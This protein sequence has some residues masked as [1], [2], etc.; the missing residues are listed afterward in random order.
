MPVIAAGEP[1]PD[2]TLRDHDGEVV[3]LSDYRGR[4]VLLVFYP[5]DFSS[6]C[7][8]QLSVY[9]EAKPEFEAEGIELADL[10]DA[11][12]AAISEHLTPGVRDVLNVP[13]AL[14]ARDGRGGTAPSAVA[15]QL[16]EVKENL[17]T[18][19]EWADAKR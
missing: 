1:A 10:T 12:F 15:T 17:A 11:Q 13:G 4:R 5:F 2:F 16:A 7:S 14:A 3:S 18:Q 8:D 19:R 9:Q 6:V